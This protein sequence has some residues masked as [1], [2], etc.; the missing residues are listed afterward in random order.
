MKTILAAVNGTKTTDPILNYITDVYDSEEYQIT[1]TTV[2]PETPA[3]SD[4]NKFGDT[5]NEES[6]DYI[7]EVAGRLQSD[8]FQTKSVIR[9]GHP[10]EEIVK[11]ANE[12]NAHSIV[13]GRRGL[14][15]TDELLLG[16]ISQFVIHN[17]ETPAVLI[18]APE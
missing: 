16:S 17:T 4:K 3:Y 14:E 11:V 10:G 5:L 13:M 9:K 8:G 7:Q 1:L 6:Q 2:V 15:T 18:T 12:L